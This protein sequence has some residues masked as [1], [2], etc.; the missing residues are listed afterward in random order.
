MSFEVFECDG[1]AC[2]AAGTLVHTKEG[3]VPIEQIKVGDYVLSKPESGEG[4][5]TYKRVVNTFIHEDK[6]V[7]S[8]DYSTLDGS[9]NGILYVTGN[10]PFWVVGVGWTSADSVEGG[11][12]LELSDGT[13]VMAVNNVPVYRTLKPGVGWSAYYD[14]DEYGA[15]FDFT[16]QKFVQNRVH[17]EDDIPYSNDPFIKVRVYNIEVED[18]HTYYVGEMGVWVHNADCGEQS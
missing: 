1:G 7:R 2:F 16:N 10:H 6:T 11:Q 3:L 14:G 15:E 5:Q 18:F 9:D 12:E 17:V 8:L 13:R 4:E